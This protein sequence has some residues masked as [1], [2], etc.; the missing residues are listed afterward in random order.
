MLPN[1]PT[2]QIGK[3]FTSQL[4]PVWS[5]ILDMRCHILSQNGFSGNELRQFG[6]YKADM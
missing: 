1:K 3:S 5:V 2:L 6:A 4:G